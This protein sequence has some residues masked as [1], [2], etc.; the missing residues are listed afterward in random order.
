MKR[1]FLLIVGLIVITSNLFSVDKATVD[2]VIDFSLTLERVYTTIQNRGI[3]ALPTNK[4]V[5]MFGAI[6]SIQ[7]V[8]DADNAPFLAEMVLVNGK[9][10]GMEYVEI[11]SSIVQL[12]GPEFENRIPKPRSR[13]RIRDP[14]E[15][16]TEVIILG[17]IIGTRENTDG[18]IIPL[19]E[20]MYIRK[21]R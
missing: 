6:S 1:K 18:S 13:T 14:I 3:E 17:N 4:S 2:E 9:W 11:Y 15:A 12:R 10:V 21:L 8:Q 19:I 20:A 5:I 16:N 7:I